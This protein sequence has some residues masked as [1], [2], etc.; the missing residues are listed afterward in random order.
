M[1]IANLN[2]RA[3]LVAPDGTATDVQ[4]ASDGRFGPSA[5][6]LYPVWAEFSDW[7]AT[8]QVGD[9]EQ[10]QP[11]QLGAPSPAPTQI[12]AFGIN[13]ADHATES[14]F[15]SPVA[16]PPVF[17]KFVS[18]LS[19]PVTTVALPEGGQTDWE[20]ELVAVIGRG[21]EGRT[22]SEDEAWDHVAGV[23]VGQDI[24]DRASQFSTPAPQ[25]GMGKSF[26]GFAPTGPWLVTVDELPN[27]DDLELQCTLDGQTM[28][29]GRTSNLIYSVPQ[30]IA[31]LSG[32]I[33]L[34]PGDL[35]FTGTPEGVGLGRDPQVFIQPGQELVTSIEGIGELR[36]KF[37]ASGEGGAKP[38][39]TLKKEGS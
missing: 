20:V 13:Y 14:G 30:L 3:V 12:V 19:G 28:Q 24:S 34:Y 23:T 36:Q 29:K 32:V 1:K 9:G 35:V 2:G 6:D 33:T 5:A 22:I 15:D 7:A 18:S 10:V 8:A 17:P 16:L 27:R 39:R 4:K 38:V 31:G 26:P 37:V 11:E 21:T 25:F